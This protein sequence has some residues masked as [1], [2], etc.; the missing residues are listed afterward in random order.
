MA[1]IIA[2]QVKQKINAIPEGVVLG[3]KDF[4][5]EPQYEPA[6]VKALN[7]LVQQGELERLSKGKYYKPKRTM[8]GILKPSATEIAKDLLEKNGEVIGYITGTAAFSGMG[9]TTQIASSIMI[10][11]N[12]YR[13]PIKRGEYTISFLLQENQI[14]EKNIPLLRILDAL[15]LI[16]EIPATTPDECIVVLQRAIAC[17]SED[18]QKELMSLSKGYTP[19]VRALLGAILECIGADTNDLKNT[20][21]GV[22]TYKIPISIQSL[23]TKNNWNIV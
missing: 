12:K 21:N 6:L 13:R 1:M 5:V 7:R 10:G 19:Y 14:T 23:P 18:E 16:R 22:T 20:L 11:T 8:F 9:L 4:Q 3:I 15:R 17:L 2:K